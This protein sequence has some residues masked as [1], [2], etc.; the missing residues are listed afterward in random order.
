MRALLVF[1]SSFLLFFSFLE[2]PRIWPNLLEMC[3]VLTSFLL[4]LL[5]QHQQVLDR[6]G[7]DHFVLSSFRASPTGAL[8]KFSDILL[9]FAGIV[10]FELGCL[11]ANVLKY[12]WFLAVLHF[13]DKALGKFL[14]WFSDL[15]ICV[16]GFR[17]SKLKKPTS[18]CCLCR[19][20]R[21]IV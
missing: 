4:P 5:I 13:W 6:L 16:Y 21:A 19:L 1:S 8:G 2:L 7:A 12:P 3:L 10:G 15:A 9:D 14:G 17:L 20:S 11:W 18:L